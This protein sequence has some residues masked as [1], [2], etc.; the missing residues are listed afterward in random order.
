MGAAGQPALLLRSS[1][2]VIQVPLHSLLLETDA[3]YFVPSGLQRQVALPGDVAHVACQVAALKGLAIEEVLAANLASVEHVYGVR[4]LG[5]EG[6][7]GGRGVEF[8]KAKIVV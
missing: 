5:E 3:P 6:L 2:L 7:P 4:P 1:L 8:V